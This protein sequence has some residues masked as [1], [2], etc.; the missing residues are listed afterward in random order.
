MKFDAFFAALNFHKMMVARGLCEKYTDMMRKDFRSAE[1]QMQSTVG[2]HA[3]KTVMDKLEQ[4]CGELPDDQFAWVLF[5]ALR[6]SVPTLDESSWL[7]RKLSDISK[8]DNLFV[9]MSPDTKAMQATRKSLAQQKK[10]AAVASASK[11]NPKGKANGKANAAP[12]SSGVLFVA[13]VA[14]A[15]LVEDMVGTIRHDVDVG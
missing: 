5:A 10:A 14:A 7:V 15:S 13:P 2:Y 4:H 8:F 9:T 1:L 12:V 3:N 6:L 11:A